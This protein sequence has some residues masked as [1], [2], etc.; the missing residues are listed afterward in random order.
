MLCHKFEM[1][2]TNWFLFLIIGRLWPRV[3]YGKQQRLLYIFT[4]IFDLVNLW[5]RELIHWFSIWTNHHARKYLLAMSMRNR[6]W[7]YLKLSLGRCAI[8]NESSNPLILHTHHRWNY[9]Q[10][11]DRQTIYDH[12][13]YNYLYSLFSNCLMFC[14]ILMLDGILMGNWLILLESMVILIWS[15]HCWTQ[16]GIWNQGKHL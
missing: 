4:N 12:P 1:S 6:S 3:R 11:C 9:S 10:E 15:W 13:K 8:S 2:H 7:R 16:F 5:Y 14:L